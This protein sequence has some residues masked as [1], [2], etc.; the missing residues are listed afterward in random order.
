MINIL[1]IINH[2][3]FSFKKNY[4]LLPPFPFKYHFYINFLFL[5]NYFQNSNNINDHFVKI[6]SNY[7]LK[8]EKKS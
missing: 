7:L 3:R 5:F 8:R 4:K 6:T 2:V 1:D